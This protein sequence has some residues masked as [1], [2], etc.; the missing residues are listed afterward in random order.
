M[1]ALLIKPISPSLLFD[2]VVR[3]LSDGGH[4]D[5]VSQSKSQTRP[6]QHLSGMVLLVEDNIINQ[7][8]AQELLKGMGVMV[9]TV[10]NGRQAAGSISL[11]PLAD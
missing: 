3:V 5:L 2:T 4:T 11:T 1:D 6:S 10:N 9:H 8:V 7:Q